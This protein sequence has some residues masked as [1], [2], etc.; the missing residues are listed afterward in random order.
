[1][2]NATS[3]YRWIELVVLFIGLPILL[4]FKP[5]VLVTIPVIST[6]LV[7]VIY[8]AVRDGRIT[9]S[10]LF[11]PTGGKYLGW[12]IVRFLVLAMLMLG[13]LKITS[14]DGLFD[15]VKSNLLLWILI[16]LVYSV[17][18]VYPQEFLYRTFFFARYQEMVGNRSL[19]LFL[20]A[21]IF[22]FAHI[23]FRNWLVLLLTFAGSLLFGITYLRTRSLA[24]TSIEHALYGLW[25]YTLGVGEMLAFPTG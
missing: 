2:K 23:I 9:R 7:Y 14:F 5:P 17:F 4:Y 1:M 21:I 13:Y 19:F 15:A 11:K 3:L 25:L 20:N 6:A 16:S 12:V 10:E 24:T 8:T 18:S 22:S